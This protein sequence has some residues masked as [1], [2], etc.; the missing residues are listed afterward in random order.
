MKTILPVCL[1]FIQTILFAQEGNPVTSENLLENEAEIS[2]AEPE[3]DFLSQQLQQ[4]RN[5]PLDLNLVSEEVLGAIFIL[6][7]LQVRH[8]ITYRKLLGPL[9]NIYELQAIPGWDIETIHRILPY[10]SIQTSVYNQS[11]FSRFRSGE[12]VILSRFSL[13]MEKAK[14]YHIDSAGYRGNPVKILVRYKYHYRNLLQFGL[15]AEKDAGESLF[16]PDQKSGFDFYTFHFFAR[17]MGK[18]KAFALGDYHINIGQ[19][20]IHWQSLAFKKS[21]ETINIKRQSGPLRPYNSTDEN[22]FHRGAALTFGKK[23][24]DIT[25]FAALDQFD[26]NKTRDSIS[27]MEYISAFQT[28]GYHR[29]KNEQADRN[30]A[31][32]L[33]TGGNMN[34]HHHRFRLG[35]NAINYWFSLP[36]KKSKEPYNLYSISGESWNNYSVDFSFTFKN[37]HSFGEAAIDKNRVAALI[38]GMLVSLH[39]KVDLAVVYRNIPAGFRSLSGNAFTNSREPNNE[40]GLYVGATVRPS[41]A[42]SIRAYA[43]HYDHPW[44]KYRTDN[45]AGGAGYLFQVSWR[46][47]RNLEIFGRC[48]VES[49][50]GNASFDTMVLSEV[51]KLRSR[52]FR[53][54]IIYKLSSQITLK[55]RVDLIWYAETGEETEKGFSGLAEVYFKSGVLP[56]TLNGR[57]QFFETGSYNTRIYA[58]ENDVMYYSSVPALFDKG[59]RFY[60]NIRLDLGKKLQIWGRFAQTIYRGKE[61]IGSGLDEIP[62]NRK[63]EARV[64]IML[65]L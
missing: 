29:T 42:W 49:R 18:V 33:V 61:S 37:L 9:V 58:Y 63:S 51:R 1:C 2:D 32:Q 64:Q 55:S 40:R 62:G 47:D 15:T 52:S 48:R 23:N 28:S 26:A 21:A 8:F 45:Q 27:G 24:I 36:I 50:S 38:N 41:A 59:S 13:V 44:L 54:Q 5:R 16:G 43:D 20:L 46:P 35:I 7:P 56:L 14:G 39:P 53:T 19:G 31:K 34:W 6:S 65:V 30:G 25:F 12:H 17:D 60:I 10:V 22:R 3:D 4:Y 57:L 11:F